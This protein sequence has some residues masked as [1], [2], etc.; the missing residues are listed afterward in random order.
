MASP[1]ARAYVKMIEVGK[2]VIDDV[3]PDKLKLE[4]QELLIEQGLYELAGVD[5]PKVE[6]EAPVEVKEETIEENEDEVIEPAPVE[7]ESAEEA[8]DEVVKKE[9]SPIEEEP[10]EEGDK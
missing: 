7:G 5:E 9:E 10:A 8:P 3:R 2:R 4:V 6:E 1:I